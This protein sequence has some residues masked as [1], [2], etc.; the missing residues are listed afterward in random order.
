[1]KELDLLL[2]RYLRERWPQASE[3]E[4]DVFEAFLELP[5]PQI[6]SYLVA[7]EPATDPETQFLIEQ[8]RKPA[9]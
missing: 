4:R 7:G 8:L 9:A 2:N 3:A 6:A 1:M 5:D